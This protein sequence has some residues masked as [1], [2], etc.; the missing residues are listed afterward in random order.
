MSTRRSKVE[1]DPALTRVEYLD[2]KGQT[3]FCSFEKNDDQ[4]A[5]V[6]VAPAGG[7]PTKKPA[8]ARGQVYATTQGATSFAWRPATPATTA[9]SCGAPAR[10]TTACTRKW[11][12]GGPPSTAGPGGVSPPPALFRQRTEPSPS[13]TISPGEHPPGQA[14]QA[15]VGAG[16]QLVAGGAVPGVHPVQQGL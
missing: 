3:S 10:T 8:V 12:G 5:E 2:D 4:A 9:G 13:G 16:E 11:P 7:Q 14:A 1:W 6:G 15:L